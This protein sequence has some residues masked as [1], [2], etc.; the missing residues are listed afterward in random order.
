MENEMD[1]AQ[2]VWVDACLA[3]LKPP[4]EWRPD[5]ERAFKKL[6]ERQRTKGNSRWIR[7]SSVGAI[8]LGMLAVLTLLPWHLLWNPETGKKNAIVEP[9]KAA[10]PAVTPPVGI[11]T[12]PLSPAR[13]PASP[14]VQ[15]S[16]TENKTTAD[17][18]L[19]PAPAVVF[20][21]AGL[22]TAPLSPA[23]SPAP[24]A[25]Q[26][27]EAPPQKQKKQPA[28]RVGN[29]V[30][31]PA[32]PRPT[33]SPSYTDEA[34]SQRIQG[35]VT[36]DV[37]IGTDGAAKV[38]RIVQGLGYGLDENARAFVEQFKC[39]PGTKDGNPVAVQVTI[40]VNFHLY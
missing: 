21:S 32:C 19:K 10:P 24:L 18:T 5:S 2:T 29:G 20:P 40:E 25:V 12:A 26:Q 16:A 37:I 13:P 1:N 6:R 22:V 31:A 38:V 23:P 8:V 11:V 14:V 27:P 34:R 39:K 17:Q 30:T 15:Q 36:L 4:A 3:R 33:D 7:V 9:V 35:T 28:E